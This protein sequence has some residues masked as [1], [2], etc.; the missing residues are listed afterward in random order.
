LRLTFE[1]Q[2][3][4]RAE[5]IADLSAGQARLRMRFAVSDT[6]R[7]QPTLA[8]IAERWRD[9]GE[10][11]KAIRTTGSLDESRRNHARATETSLKRVRNDI[12]SFRC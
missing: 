8:A 9:A 11:F 1:C 7:A 4:N 6:S 10:G 5:G 12:A 2:A 3:Q